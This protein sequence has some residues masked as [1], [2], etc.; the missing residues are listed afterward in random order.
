MG[1]GRG[2]LCTGELVPV[3]DRHRLRPFFR[4]WKP[5]LDGRQQ[6]ATPT[7]LNAEPLYSGTNPVLCTPIR[8]PVAKSLAVSSPAERY[9]S[10]NWSSMSATASCRRL[11]PSVA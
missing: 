8:I 7:F 3:G 1:I 10:N 11:K 6:G 5:F 9:R 4:R 2:G